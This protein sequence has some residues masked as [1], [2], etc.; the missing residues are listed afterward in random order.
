MSKQ[1]RKPKDKAQ[2]WRTLR[3]VVEYKTKSDL[4]ENDLARDVEYYLVQS[5]MTARYSDSSVV[6]K[7]FSRMLDTLHAARPRRLQAAIRALDAVTTRL[8]KL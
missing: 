5:G 4:S 1:P 3:C 8:R 6:A 7:G 2:Q